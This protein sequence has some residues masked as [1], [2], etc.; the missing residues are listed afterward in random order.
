M[1]WDVKEKVVYNVDTGATEILKFLR[2]NNIHHN[3][4]TMLNVDHADQQR[5]SYSVYYWSRNR[6]W[7]WSLVFCILGVFLT[8]VY[9]LY[10][11][12]CED[13]GI[14][15]VIRMAHLEFRKGVLLAW[16]NCGFHA[17]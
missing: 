14:P 12:T 15:K 5:G 2:M 11:N 8:N 4:S 9:V 6:T 13:Y 1:R 16:I 10:L 7:W 3:N 17:E